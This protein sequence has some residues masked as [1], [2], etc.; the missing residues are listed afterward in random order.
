MEF[1]RGKRVKFSCA[2]QQFTMFFNSDMSPWIR[3]W[4]SDWWICSET[5]RHKQLTV[6]YAWMTWQ[7]QDM[8]CSW[9]LSWVETQT[10]GSEATA[11]NYR[12]FLFCL[13]FFRMLSGATPHTD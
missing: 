6:S 5:R 10:N 1:E 9:E 7:I 4:F 13:S 11:E 8:T 2:T 12:C 3:H